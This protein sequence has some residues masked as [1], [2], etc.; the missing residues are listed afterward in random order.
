MFK[1]FSKIRFNLI[2]TNKTGKYIKYA[3]GEIFLVVIGILIALQ[4]N[5]WNEDRKERAIEQNYLERLLVDLEND[6]TTLTFSKGLSA[7]RIHQIR[8][9]NTMVEGT[10]IASPNEVIESIEKVTWRS[11][12]PLS[13][14]VYNELLNSG[15]MSLIKSEE[16]RSLLTSYYDDADHWE[17]IL[18]REDAQ[19]EFSHATAGILSIEVLT[20]I[21]NAASLRNV[22]V[23]EDFSLYLEPNE[24]EDIVQKFSTN[25]D[26]IKWLPQIHHYH[27]LSDKVIGNLSEQNQTI[28]TLVE[29]QIK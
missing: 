27:V 26:A 8:I 21:E 17:M 6:N 1:F 24:F 2:G 22:D 12:L 3:T 29:S 18:N 11:Y 10:S 4:V 5:N 20:A 13:K 28:R 7:D 25:E 14:I 16:L 23:E 15:Q 9:L 19:K